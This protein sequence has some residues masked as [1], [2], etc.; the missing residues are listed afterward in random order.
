MVM[1]CMHFK[2]CKEGCGI[3]I[4]CPTT[5]VG[6]M[7]V[8]LF[9][10]LLVVAICFLQCWQWR[11]RK[12]VCRE[13][14]GKKNCRW[15]RMY[16]RGRKWRWKGKVLKRKKEKKKGRRMRRCEKWKG[17]RIVG[18]RSLHSWKHW[19]LLVVWVVVAMQQ[20]ANLLLVEKAVVEGV[21]AKRHVVPLCS[22]GWVRD[23]ESEGLPPHPW[24]STCCGVV[25]WVC[26]R[27]RTP[28]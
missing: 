19:V 2:V 4:V 26:T 20:E 22:F 11:P 28:S 1:R 12:M 13:V 15:A 27:L 21:V 14:R 17:R 18:H 23:L 5:D 3:C 10:V 7:H 25:W 9:L 24:A 16:K 8:L 6:D